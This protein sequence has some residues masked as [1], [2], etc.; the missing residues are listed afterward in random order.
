[1]K[2][3]PD[4]AT[5]VNDDALLEAPTPERVRDEAAVAELARLARIP[6]DR[7]VPYCRVGWPPRRGQ[8]PFSC[9]EAFCGRVHSMLWGARQ[10][11]YF[12]AKAREWNDGRSI[13]EAERAVRTACDAVRALSEPQRTVFENVFRITAV[14]NELMEDDVAPGAAGLAMLEALVEAFAVVTGRSPTFEARGGRG[15]PKGR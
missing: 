14:C 4:G 1:M 5:A 6:A 9:L 11:A 8:P 13:R 12:R 7:E 3:S 15:R 2:K 10:V